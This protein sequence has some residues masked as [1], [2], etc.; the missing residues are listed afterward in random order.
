[1]QSVVSSKIV[2][3]LEAWNLRNSVAAHAAGIEIEAPLE[4]RAPQPFL[5]DLIQ[6]L[7]DRRKALGMTQTDVNDEI[8]AADRLVNK[9]ECG[10]RMP[11]GF[12]LFCWAK[13]LGG[14]LVFVAD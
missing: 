1:M 4:R 6:Q 5:R 13:V 11:S 9:W 14:R 10:D 3:P 8:G 2:S 7:V 12:L